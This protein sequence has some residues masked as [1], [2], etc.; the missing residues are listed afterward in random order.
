MGFVGEVHY[1]KGIFVGIV[2]DDPAHG[3]NDGQF[4]HRIRI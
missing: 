1:A 4:D 2:T 3:K